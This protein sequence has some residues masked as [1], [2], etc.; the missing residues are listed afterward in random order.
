MRA[1]LIAHAMAPHHVTDLASSLVGH[2]TRC[3]ALRAAAAA[4]LEAGQWDEFAGRLETLRAGLYAHFAYEEDEL[5]PQF[6]RAS[7]MREATETLRAEHRDMR[8][9]LDALA[10]AS[11]AHDPEGCRAEFATVTQLLRQHQV[12]E[13]QMLYPTL[14]RILEG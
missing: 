13:E 12:R 14:S 9:I 1:F 7:G 5:F 4:A 8:A 10:A 6:E 3:E 11:A 2:H